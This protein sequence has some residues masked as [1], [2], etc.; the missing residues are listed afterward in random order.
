MFP[1]P[2]CLRPVTLALPS[3][4]WCSEAAAAQ[5][6]Q[7]PWRAAAGQPHCPSRPA[8][9]HLWPH[10][11]PGSGGCAGV[12]VAIGPEMTKQ[13]AGQKGSAAPS[14]VKSSRRNLSQRQAWACEVFPPGHQASTQEGRL[15]HLRR[16]SARGQLEGKLTQTCAPRMPRQLAVQPPGDQLWSRRC[17]P[18]PTLT[19]PPPRVWGVVSRSQPSAS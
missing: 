16:S 11:A 8:P 10:L 4:A 15:G 3:S 17:H 19:P 7:S 9:S 13:D 1:Q 18:S 14:G 6:G 2:S 5:P 12:R